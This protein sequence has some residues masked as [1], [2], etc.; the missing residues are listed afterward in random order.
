MSGKRSNFVWASALMAI[1]ER[2]RAA[3]ATRVKA[4]KGN[5]LNQGEFYLVVS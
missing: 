2:I 5:L 1:T 3:K 4:N